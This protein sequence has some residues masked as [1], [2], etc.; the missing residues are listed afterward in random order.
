MQQPEN[1]TGN[2][3]CQTP[4]ARAPQH[5]EGEA[6]NKELEAFSYSVS[7]D[8]RAPLRHIDGFAD[9]LQKHAAADLDEKGS[10]YLRTIS[11]SAKQMGALIDDLL[12]FSRVGRAELRLTTVDLNLIVK[13]VLDNLA[14]D[15]QGRRIAWE[16][17]TLPAVHGDLAMLRQVLT[18][19]IG[20]ALKY[21]RTREKARIEIGS[22]NGAHSSP[23][24]VIVYIRDN[25]VG[26]DM[27]Y[28]HKLFR[29]FQRLHS[30]SEFEGTG[31]GLAN[32][33]RIIARHEGR[34]W[35]EG[36]VDEGSTFYFSLPRAVEK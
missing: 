8:M 28:V 2:D 11:E 35:A 12:A 21:T 9:M 31:I 4:T 16:I 27:Q 7:H 34:T 20:N 18:N 19:L 15:V 10:R 13:S 30:A 17:G 5:C 26:F 23:E 14:Y 1:Y 3:Q 29:V 6:A 36:R 33:Q 32:V 24:E 22:K 25:G